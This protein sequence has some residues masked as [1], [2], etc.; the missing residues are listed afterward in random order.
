MTNNWKTLHDNMT[1]KNFAQ[2]TVAPSAQS[3]YLALLARE[4]CYQQGKTVTWDQVINDKTSLEFDTTGL[5]S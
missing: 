2:E 3:H 5:K 1:K 4:A